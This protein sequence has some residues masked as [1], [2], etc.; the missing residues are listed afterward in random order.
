MK[1]LFACEWNTNGTNDLLIVEDG[2]IIACINEAL[3]GVR[4]HAQIS[5]ELELSLV[6]EDQVLAY[7]DEYADSHE[8]CMEIDVEQAFNK[9]AVSPT[10]ESN[11]V[12]DAIAEHFPEIRN[13]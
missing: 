3:F 5:V 11:E 7:S 13:Y 12:I 10:Q 4:V 9:V 2:E 8:T 6:F 1:R